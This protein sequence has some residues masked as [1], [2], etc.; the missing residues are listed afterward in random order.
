[1]STV[2]CRQFRDL[3]PDL[4][5]G[6]LAGDDRGAAISHV[7]S[8][9]SCR[10]HLDGLVAVA[11]ELLLLAPSVEPDIGFESRVMARLAAGGA[12]SPPAAATEPGA[13][14]R[15]PGA[16][17][18]FGAP[19]P[20]RTPQSNPRF[21]RTRRL[22]LAVA[23]ALVVVVGVSGVV[24]GLDRGRSEGRQSAF[25]QQVVAGKEL[26]ARTVVVWGDGGQSTCQLVAFPHQGSQPARLVIYLEEPTVPPD[27]Y[28]VFAVPAGGGKAVL[29]GTIAVAHGEGT[30]TVAIPASAGP[31]DGVR[32]MEGP[33]N[34]KY[35][36]TFAS[37]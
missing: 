16:P 32:V 4:A 10:R 20:A 15:P 9:A 21:W 37:V 3:A 24:T 7:A 11:D 17:R 35:S 36:A 5:L 1:M 27:D 14:E 34:T 13:R 12:F 31:V 19:R 6:L 22:S 26:A 33:G 23:A 29:V 8:C 25:R 2:D 30:L 18:A 28:Q